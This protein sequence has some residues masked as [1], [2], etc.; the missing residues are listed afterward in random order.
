[1]TKKR[2]KFK[3]KT[4]GQEIIEALEGF[5]RSLARGES[6][7]SKYTVHSYEIPDPAAFKPSDIKALRNRLSASQAI[8]ARLVGISPVLVEHWERGER[9]PHPVACRLLELIARDPAAYM[10]QYLRRKAG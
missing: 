7:E 3:K 10:K 2:N 6:I 9:T 4:F 5:N 8:F 1:M